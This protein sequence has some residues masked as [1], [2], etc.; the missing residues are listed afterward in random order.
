MNNQGKYKKLTIV[1]MIVA[2]VISVCSLA[3]VVIFKGD[4]EYQE[5]NKAFYEETSATRQRTTI[6][7][8]SATDADDAVDVEIKIPVSFVLDSVNTNSQ[9]TKEQQDAGFKSAVFDGNGTV[10]Y[11]ISKADHRKFL[12]NYKYDVVT[13]L[14][15]S[16]ASEYAYFND[17]DYNEDLS[18]FSVKVNGSSFNNADGEEISTKV[19]LPSMLYQMYAMIETNCQVSIVDDN[20][21]RVITTYTP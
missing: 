3:W 11:T 6:P 8:E 14:E 10:T 16:L 1:V 13:D 15:V 5:T 17:L 21:N 18:K 12:M 19:S 20:T 7:D 4:D 9:L 2:V